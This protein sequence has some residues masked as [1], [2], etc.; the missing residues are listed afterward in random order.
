MIIQVYS[1]RIFTKF[2]YNLVSDNFKEL[3]SNVLML[4]GFHRREDDFLLKFFTVE[5]FRTCE[6][7]ML[8]FIVIVSKSLTA[9][10]IFVFTI[11][12]NPLVMF[13]FSI[14]L[15]LVICW[16]M[17]ARPKLFNTNKTIEGSIT[18]IA[19]AV[20]LLNFSS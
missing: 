9:F 8:P 3:F 13:S 16:F 4:S 12:K 19:K 7:V 17:F 1:I 18:G 14:S 6:R 10:I 11:I 15:L 5:F 2:A 20:D